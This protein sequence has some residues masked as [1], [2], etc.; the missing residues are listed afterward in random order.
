MNRPTWDEY[1]IQIAS[2]VSKRGT[3][4]RRIYGAV[5]VKDNKIISTGYNGAPIGEPNCTTLGVCKRQELNIPSGERYELCRS[6]HAEA[7]AIVQGDYDKMEGATIYIAGWEVS[8]EMNRFGQFTSGYAEAKPCMM[9]SRMI[10]NAK[11]KEVKW[12]MKDGNLVT[13]LASELGE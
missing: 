5:I 4:L 13:K 11:I 8:K 7:N 2:D 1:F 10:K 3:C 12:R 9:C 6:V